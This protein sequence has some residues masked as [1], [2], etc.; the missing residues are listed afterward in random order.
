MKVRRGTPGKM[1]WKI[2]HKQLVNP[3]V[4]REYKRIADNKMREIMV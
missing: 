1:N 3:A 4:W 2:N